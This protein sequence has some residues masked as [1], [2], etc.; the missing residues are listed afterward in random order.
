MYFQI[1]NVDVTKNEI[2]VLKKNIVGDDENEI[3]DN[4][5]IKI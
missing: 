1:E 3:W 2:V 4:K 5:K